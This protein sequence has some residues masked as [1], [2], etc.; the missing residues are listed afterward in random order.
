M[1]LK[2]IIDQEKIL[3]KEYLELIGLSRKIRKRARVEDIIYVNGKKA[4]NFYP[5]YKGDILEL[6]FD[7]QMNEEILVN[8]KPLDI[9]YE[10]DY[11]IIINKENDISSQPSQKH[12]VHN[13]IS[14]AKNYFIKK[15]INSN[16]HLVNRLDYSTSGLMII[17]KDGITH[18]EFTKVNIVKKY[19]CEIQGH[20]Q[21]TSGTI[22]L[23]ID[24]EEAPS[25]KRFV[26]EN[27]KQSVTH[28]KVLQ[29]TSDTDF[30][31]VTLQTGRTH[32]IRVHFSHL[33]FPLVGDVLYGKK[34]D[35]LKLHCYYLSF[36]HPWTNEKLE[37]INYPKWIGR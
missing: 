33:G 16:V 23:P 37:F 7:E 29:S 31:E 9:I 22:D 20:I 28:Y 25:I 6:I 1:I 12:P 5:L 26:S 3:V 10:D 15:N 4:K 24:R 14:C 19:I 8:D 27:G 18:F 34:D 2:Y 21:P 35:I 13:V 17:A 11:I 32:Q 30:V 36:N